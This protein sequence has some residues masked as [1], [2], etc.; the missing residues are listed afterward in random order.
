MNLPLVF[1]V[2]VGVV[3]FHELPNVFQAGPETIV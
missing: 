2:A 3:V 1:A